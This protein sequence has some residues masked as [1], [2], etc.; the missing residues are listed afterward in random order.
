[1]GESVAQSKLIFYLLQVLDWLS[2]PQGWF[3]I[4]N[5]NIYQRRRRFEHPLAPDVA[6]FKWFSRRP[7]LAISLDTR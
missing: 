6:V 3:V 7:Q 5:L 2:R 4:S 1:M